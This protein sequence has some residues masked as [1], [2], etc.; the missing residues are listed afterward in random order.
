[1]EGAYIDLTNDVDGQ[2][3]NIRIVNNVCRGIKKSLSRDIGPNY[4]DLSKES[5][6]HLFK[7]MYITRPKLTT[8][9]KQPIFLDLSGLENSLRK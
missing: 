8:V 5:G 4:I 7:G 3:K 6:F 2:W 1:L 9:D